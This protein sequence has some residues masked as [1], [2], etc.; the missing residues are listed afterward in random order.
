V[1]GFTVV[2]CEKRGGYVAGAVTLERQVRGLHDVG[3]V[4]VSCDHLDTAFFGLRTLDRGDQHYAWPHGLCLLDGIES[5]FYIANFLAREKAQLELV[6]SNNI[7]DRHDLIPQQRWNL[8][9]DKA[10]GLFI[11]HHWV[12]RIERVRVNFLDT[13]NSVHIRPSD[14]RAALVARNNGVDLF[15]SAAALNTIDN[16]C[17]IVRRHQWSAPVTVAGV[18]RKINSVHWPHLMADTLQRENSGRVTDMAKR[19][20]RLDRQDIH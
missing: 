20:V 18:V 12:A 3:I 10:A 13:G 15:K 17:N 16:A 7:G 14:I 4:A 5:F 8:I 1:F 6:R 2:A 11:S 19:Y 9:R